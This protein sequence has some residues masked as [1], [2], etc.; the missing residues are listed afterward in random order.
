[1]SAESAVTV[2]EVQ[3]ASKESPTAPIAEVDQPD[4]DDDDDDD[5]DDD[6]IENDEDTSEEELEEEEEEEDDDDNDD[7]DDEKEEEEEE[8]EVHNLN[9]GSPDSLPVALRSRKKRIRAK[10]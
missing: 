2:V 4:M 10:G 3:L 1:M 8:E 6:Q 9:S 7:D 5:D